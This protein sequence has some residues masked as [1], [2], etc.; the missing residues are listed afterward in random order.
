MIDNFRSSK[1][2]II[3][4]TARDA[5]TVMMLSS[6]HWRGRAEIVQVVVPEAVPLPPRSFTQV[7]LITPHHTRTDSQTMTHHLLLS[8]T[9]LIIER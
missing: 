7:T 2:I 5:V 1:E 8:A 9:I 4:V 3:T 6:P